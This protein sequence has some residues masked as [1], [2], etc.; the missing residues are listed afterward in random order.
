MTF[1][2]RLANSGT[3]LANAPSSVVHTGLRTVGTRAPSPAQG[4]HAGQHSAR[5][6]CGK[7]L[8]ADVWC[9]GRFLRGPG[10]AAAE[11]DGRH[12]L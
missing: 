4:E 7:V 8:A 11:G 5:G 1:V 10:G 12:R 9:P 6:C 2:L 3:S